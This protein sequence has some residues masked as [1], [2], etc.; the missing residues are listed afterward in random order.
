MDP[1]LADRQ[2]SGLEHDRMIINYANVTEAN[3]KRF[4]M[5]MVILKALCPSPKPLAVVA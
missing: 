2:A 1:A 5:T 4:P 3:L